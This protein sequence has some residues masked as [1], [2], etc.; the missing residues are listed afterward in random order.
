MS[1]SGLSFLVVERGPDAGKRIKLVRFPVSIGRDPSNDI[2]LADDEVSR[3]HVRLKQRG[4][5]FVLE[6]LESRNGSY[7]NGDKVL[8]SILKNSDKIL[9]GSTELVFHS[10]QHHVQFATEMN[11]LNIPVSKELMKLGP[12]NVTDKPNEDINPV[13]LNLGNLGQN[14]SGDSEGVRA[15]YDLHGNILVLDNLED[16]S[17]TFLKCVMKLMP[18]ASR[19][20]LFILTPKQSQLLP[21]ASRNG[22]KKGFFI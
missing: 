19:S 17:A 18:F 10:Q 13:R 7:V 12:I 6:D 4:R 8:N 9:L 16:A 1:D 15:I 22:T 2:I 5:L 20:A 14:I 11:Q 3:H 21:V